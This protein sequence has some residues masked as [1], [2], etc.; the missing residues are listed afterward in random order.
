MYIILGGTGHVGS[1]VVRALLAK[2]EAISAFTR[3]AGRARGSVGSG[4]KLIEG[5]VED[6]DSLRMA[7]KQGRRALLLNPPAEFTADTD[8]VERRRVRNILAALEGSGLEKVVAISTGGAQPGERLGDLNV[9]W[10]LEEGLRRRSIPAAINRGAYYMSNWEGM[11]E[12][13]RETGKLQTVFDADLA[14]PMVAPADVGA[15][16]AQRLLSSV[17]DVDV[18]YIEGPRRYTPRDVA[19]AFAGALGRDVEVVVT[20]RNQWESSFR[21]MGFS[22]AAAESYSRM[23][24]ASIDAGFD[25]PG[26][27]VRGEISL[28]SYVQGVASAAAGGAAAS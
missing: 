2:G 25:M 7:F 15:F 22:A 27:A 5:D 1:A 20:P 26:D 10:E 9:L 6:M 11:L 17:Q 19:Q 18:R 14:I 23:T 21:Q 28:E 8:V 16:A 13:V 12:P 4:A 3:D 24:A